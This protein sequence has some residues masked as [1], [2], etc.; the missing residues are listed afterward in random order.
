MTKAISET[1]TDWTVAEGQEV[2]GVHESLV[3]TEGVTTS[4]KRQQQPQQSQ[5]TAPGLRKDPGARGKGAGNGSGSNG[6]GKKGS[7]AGVI[8][9]I[10]RL[11][12]VSRSGA[13]LCG[14]L[15]ST[16]GC[17]SSD[18][19]CPQWGRHACGYITADDG[20]ICHDT[21]HGYTGHKVSKR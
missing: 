18:K 17:K 13:K 11:A 8:S 10:G 4:A 16:K 19:N 9:K 14:A 20:T 15:N 1:S 5:K 6:G 12:S 2:V 7:K 3:T 21:G